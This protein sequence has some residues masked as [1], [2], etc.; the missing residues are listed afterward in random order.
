MIEKINNQ[1]SKSAFKNV[2]TAYTRDRMME[3]WDVASTH[4]GDVVDIEIISLASTYKVICSNGFS[5]KIYLSPVKQVDIY[6]VLFEMGLAL[7][8]LIYERESSCGTWV[9]CGWV[10]GECYRKVI[11]T[12]QALKDIKPDLWNKM[13]K[14]LGQIGNV[15]WDGEGRR[16]GVSDA[17]WWNFIVTPEEDVVLIDTKKFQVDFFPEKHLLLPI[18]F[19]EHTPTE[20]KIAFI[21]GYSSMITKEHPT[22]GV[23]VIKTIEIFMRGLGEKLAGK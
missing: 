12:E 16:L 3:A 7:P 19:N 15:V 6:R 5:Y 21:S 13:G 20:S 23:D 2:D 14:L 4:L 10:D 17:L 22:V 8:E 11:N 18:F 9:I 1:I